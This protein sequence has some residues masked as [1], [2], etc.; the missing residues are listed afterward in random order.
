MRDEHG[1]LDRG[2][3]N[4]LTISAGP[5]SVGR[6]R[7]L[8]A[9]NMTLTGTTN[10]GANIATLAQHGGQLVNLGAAMRGTLA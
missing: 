4:T 3:G 9:D 10:A 5:P 7:H 1:G 8:Y 6:R 2:G